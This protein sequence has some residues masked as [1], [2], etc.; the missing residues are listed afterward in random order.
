M[1]IQKFMEQSPNKF[2][3]QKHVKFGTILHN[4]RLWSRISPEWLKLSK[5]WQQIDRERFLLR[6]AN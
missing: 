6:S 3:G 1:Q 5:I 2:W 4:F